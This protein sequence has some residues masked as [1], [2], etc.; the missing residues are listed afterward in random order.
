MNSELFVGINRPCDL[1]NMS[2]VEK[3]HY[4]TI[5]VPE[6]VKARE[7]FNITV[8][9]GK[10]LAHPDKGDHFIQWVD[11]YAGEAYLA[12]V[13]FT[14]TVSCSPVSITLKLNYDCTI[15]AISRCNQ[16]GM[17]EGSKKIKI[18]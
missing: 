12:R 5:E 6:S 11:L 18:V 16:H 2:D 3:K 1:S 8:S 14:P 15:R 9:V 13:D 4:P 7:P 10:E 17:W